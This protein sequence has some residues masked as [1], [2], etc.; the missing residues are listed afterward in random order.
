MQTLLLVRAVPSH[1]SLNYKNTKVSFYCAILS[2]RL[3]IRLKVERNGELLLYAEEVIEQGPEF[4][5]ENRS[6]VIDDRVRKAMI[7]HHHVDY[8]FCQFWSIDSD[9]NWFVMYHLD[10]T[11]NNN[12]N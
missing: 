1:F 3:P 5:H 9:F 11:V 8:Y 2:F 7:L 6:A 12:K 10:Q 4:G